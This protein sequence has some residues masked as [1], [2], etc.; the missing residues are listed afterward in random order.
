[1][2]LEKHELDGYFIKRVDAR[3]LRFQFDDLRNSSQTIKT[4]SRVIRS[5]KKTRKV[6]V[7]NSEFSDLTS[8]EKSLISESLKR[9]SCLQDIRLNFGGSDGQEESPELHPLG[10]GLR[11]LRGLKSMSLDF[12]LMN[13]VSKKEMNRF[14][15]VL[16]SLVPL[17][18]VDFK[19]DG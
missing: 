6:E 15:R 13:K 7:N 17:Q 5:S 2:Q 16:K 1:M 14:G 4:L 10:H 19:F 11:T 9:L 8:R 18:K 3:R 12:A